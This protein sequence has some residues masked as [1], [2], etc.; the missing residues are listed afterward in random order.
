[1]LRRDPV[2]FGKA[3]LPSLVFP[4]LSLPAVDLVR[5]DESLPSRL[6]DDARGRLV[7]GK[8][9]RGSVQDEQDEVGPADRLDGLF[10]NGPR[11]LLP[12]F[13]VVPPGVQEPVGAPVGQVGD[14]LED[15]AGHSGQIVDE[16]PAAPEKP[17]EE[18]GLADV[19]PS[20]D[21]DPEAWRA[22]APFRGMPPSSRSV[23]RGWENG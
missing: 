15:V 20:G 21:D 18:D 4:L 13:R 14:R 23:N 8:N 1:M 5:D 17:V 11:D 10:A 7:S 2:D 22:H 12:L 9:P 16:R 3:E 19:R 6:A